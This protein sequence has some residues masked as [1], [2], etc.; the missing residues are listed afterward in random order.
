MKLQSLQVEQVRQFRK[1]LALENLQ[2]GIN[3]IH[4]PNESGKSTLVRAI[5]AAFFERHRSKSVE[6]LR[7]WG[8]S[9]A[10][11]T[12]ILSFEHNQQQWQLT[13]SFLQRKR[14]DLVM[15]QTAFSGEDAEEKLAELLGYQF[16]K[17][18]ASRE[19]HWGIPGLLWV[20]QGTGQDIEKAVEHAGN[21]LKSALNG[22]VGEVASSAGDDVIQAVQARR[23][24]LLTATGKPREEYGQLEKDR[25]ILRSDIAGLEERIQQYQTQVDRLGTLNEDYQRNER[26]RPWDDAHRKLEQAREQYRQVEAL[27]QQQAQ[28]QSARDHILQNLGLLHENQNQLQNQRKKFE[29]REKEREQ[30][31]RVLEQEVARAPAI[32]QAV[33]AA[34]ADYQAALKAVELARLA[35]RRGQLQQ[36]I[37]RLEDQQKRLQQN[38]DKAREFQG[39]LDD[40]RKQK[41]I[42][43]TD[44]AAVERVRATQRQLDEE[45][46]RSQTIATRLTWQLTPGHSLKLNDREIQGQGEERL[47][48]D[49]TLEIPGVGTLG[50]TPGGEDLASTRRTLAHLQQSLDDQLR[51]LGV[52]ITA[53]AEHR[54]A[55]YQA[56]DRALGH[57]EDLIR[58]V[59]PNGVDRLTAEHQDSCTQLEQKTAEMAA[60]PTHDSA[61]ESSVL[62]LANAESRRVTAESRLSEAETAQRQHQADALA[63]KQNCDNA[64]R[65]WQQL[66]DELDTDARQQQLQK[67]T[68]DIERAEQRRTDLDQTLQARASQIQQARPDLLAQDVERYQRTAES[69]QT[70]QEERA[71]ELR[72]IRVRLEAWG[73]EG[74][75]ELCSE[76]V[77]ELEHVNRRYLEL[78]R[79]AQALD[80]LLN[81]LTDKRQALTRRLQAPLQKHLD[82][83]LSVLFPQA[84]LEVDEHLVPGKFSRGNELGQM[85]ELSFGAREQMGL[86]SRLAY[87][88]LLRDAG[89][90]TLIILDDTLVHSDA[91]RLDGMKRI[92]F[93]A[94]QRHQ[95]LLFTCHPEKWRDIGVEPRDLESLK[96]RALGV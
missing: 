70:A 47:L 66:K 85:A 71:R 42:N 19:E 63:A 48:T 7:P 94:A 33:E 55:R 90:P 76:K 37:S 93:D 95:I 49:S 89:R 14:C 46:I 22:L 25:D 80:L 61:T 21:H 36:D 62:S 45:Q 29:Q 16:P 43:M 8:D 65:E 79:R 20:E 82:H 15:D 59:A 5:R 72:D 39:Q 23:A 73:A 88:D 78:Q 56:A 3:L 57:L 91:E 30:A 53:E 9:A 77:G 11:P 31:Q 83:Y 17:K 2:P 27:Q 69:L 75:E 12:I 51:A 4:G 44:T 32:E 50:V 54:L 38:L 58:S 60:M 1:P 35:E 41:Q 68:G 26:E 34:R 96:A 81:L 6:D 28:D 67:L 64:Q 86:I 74:L 52:P 92:L 10:A 13:K 40:A 24:E 84:T 87:A 18:G